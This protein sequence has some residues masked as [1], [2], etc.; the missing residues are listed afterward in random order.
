MLS[1][2]RI[3]RMLD[4]LTVTNTSEDINKILIEVYS[5]DMNKQTE[6]EFTT[7]ED[8]TDFMLDCSPTQERFSITLK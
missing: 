8:A 3:M 5:L 1:H 7:V 6:G 2:S 4:T